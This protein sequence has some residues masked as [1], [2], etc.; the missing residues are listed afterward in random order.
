[1]RIGRWRNSGC[2]MMDRTVEIEKGSVSGLTVSVDSE[3][4][5]KLVF[6]NKVVKVTYKGISTLD[7]AIA[8]SINK[9][10]GI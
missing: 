5:M 8:E 4:R 6:E 7:A 1:M 2:M 10:M 9:R 3:G